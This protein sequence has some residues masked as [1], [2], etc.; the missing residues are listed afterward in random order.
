MKKLK[1]KKKGFTLI[2]VLV[3]GGVSLLLGLTIVNVFI[4]SRRS[5]D[6]AIG[7]AD[8]VRATRVPMDRLGYYITAGSSIRG[9]ETILFPPSGVS[10][11]NERGQTL[12]ITDPDTWYRYIIIRTTEDFLWSTYDPNEIMTL[13]LLPDTTHANLINAYENDAQ[14]IYDYVLWFE[15]DTNGIDALPNEDKVLAVARI[16]PLFNA[17]TGV[18]TFRDEAWASGN[19]F[20]D[21]DP[22]TAAKV[23][24]RNVEDVTFKREGSAAVDVSILAQTQ[25]RT[26]A[27]NQTKQFRASQRYHVVSELMQ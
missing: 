22:N 15:D 16:A 24:A 27:G 2:E 6:H 11:M 12:S 3:A 7:T 4:Q 8:L 21:L 25:V 1:S 20:A 13:H 14:R 17:G 5:L 18:T 23:I 10:G 19:P 26:A 9:E